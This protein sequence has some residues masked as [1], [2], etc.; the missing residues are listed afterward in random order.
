MA[1]HHIRPSRESLHGRFGAALDPCL[2]VESGDVVRFENTLD[3]SW[4]MGQH[5][6]PGQPRPKWG[7][8]EG[9]RD[10]GPALH[11]PVFIRG[12]RPGMVV[13][14]GIRA[15]VPGSWGWTWVGANP[16][17]LAW[18]SDLD[19][20]L[21]NQA[22]IRWELDA[23]TMTG[24]SELGHEVDLRPFPGIIGLCPAGDGLHDA[25][26]PRR[27][28]G[29]FDCPALVAGTTLLLPVEVEGGLL[30]VGDGHARQG[31]GEVA[32]TAIECPLACLE[33]EVVL[34]QDLELDGPRAK[35]QEGWVTFGFS[36]DLELAAKEAMR[37]MIS[38]VA[39][40]HGVDRQTALAIASPLVDLRITQMV[41]GV[42]GVHALL[43][44]R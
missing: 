5:G 28:G 7:P 37:D 27:V 8:R 31:C 4:G 11:G 22:L 38:L 20:D 18:L 12:A 33:L 15:V 26:P 10:Q 34:R 9:E 30:S 40:K 14:L 1:L 23:A 43:H 16:P 21:D 41:N 2:T 39:E 19:L 42:R 32:G 25:I 29:N 24:R 13:E 3:V 6:A 36:T 44:E 17:A 35:T